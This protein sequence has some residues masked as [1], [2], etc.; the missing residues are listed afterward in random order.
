MTTEVSYHVLT[1][2]KY[3]LNFVFSQQ[4]IL[5][6]LPGIQE[7]STL[8]KKLTKNPKLSQCLILPVHST[9]ASDQ[10]QQIFNRPPSGMRKVVLSTNI[11]ETSITID[12]I[13]FVIDSCKVR[14]TRYD[15]DKKMVSLDETWVSKASAQQRYD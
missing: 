14:E 3:I 10:Q 6:F 9:L 13:V 2:H 12:D 5:I 1:I 7:I 8:Y 11:A 4:G 15:P